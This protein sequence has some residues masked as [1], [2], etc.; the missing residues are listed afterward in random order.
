MKPHERRIEATYLAYCSP[1]EAYGWLE[2]HGPQSDKI[3]TRHRAFEDKLLEYILCSRREPLIDLALARYAHTP[4]IIRKVFRR[5]GSGVRCAA[6]TN[7]VKGQTIPAGI[8]CDGNELMTLAEAG[9]IRDLE[10]FASNVGLNEKGIISLVR[11]ENEFSEISESRYICALRAL[12]NNPRLAAPYGDNRRMDYWAQAKYDSVFDEVWS[13]SLTLPADQDWAERLEPLIRNCLPPRGFNFDTAIT[14]WRIDLPQNEPE[15][16][17]WT[18]DS[19]YLRSAI[20]DALEP[21]DILRDSD[22]LAL[23]LSFYRRLDPIRFPAWPDHVA[24]DFNSWGSDE[25]GYNV[26]RNKR[27]WRTAEQRDR[28]MQLCWAIPD[29]TADMQ[30]PQAYLDTMTRMEKEF[31]L[32]FKDENQIVSKASP[33]E[34]ETRE[35]LSDLSSKIDRLVGLAA[36]PIKS[37]WF[38]FG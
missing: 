20:A 19:F 37:R 9:H 36:A 24:R 35:R 33:L 17:Y 10:A 3:S 28:L 15:T 7:P 31:P 2:R 11:R 21:D 14:R 30:L 27:L 13:L 1:D 16:Y 29:P 12:A 6:W 22:D 18:G 26:L 38:P 34:A 8:W 5:G 23:R 32:W 25:V 4:S